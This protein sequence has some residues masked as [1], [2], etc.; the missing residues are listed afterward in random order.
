MGDLPEPN[1]PKGTCARSQGG[2]PAGVHALNTFGLFWDCLVRQRQRE[3]KREDG[4][5]RLLQHLTASPAAPS[6]VPVRFPWKPCLDQSTSPVAMDF[7]NLYQ[8]CGRRTAAS[9]DT[10]PLTPTA[11]RTGSSWVL[12]EEAPVCVGLCQATLLKVA[13]GNS[14]SDTAVGLHRTRPAQGKKCG[15]LC[16]RPRERKKA[17]R[18]PQ[19]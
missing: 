18:I 5:R 14:Q 15:Q 9:G 2:V 19:L 6:P 13:A 1:L 4:S 12:L 7:R 3:L 10:Q 17:R 16:L 11:C 8:L